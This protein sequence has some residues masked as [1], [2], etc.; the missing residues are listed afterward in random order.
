MWGQSG[1]VFVSVTPMQ[2]W[3]RQQLKMG[4]AKSQ[5]ALVEK[6][7]LS[8]D[9]GAVEPLIYAL[10]GK[11]SK[12]RCT[13]AKALWKFQDRRAV[14]PLIPLLGDPVSLVRATA[15]ESLGRLGDPKAVDDLVALMRDA[16]PVVR[17]IAARNL[18]RLGWRPASD[19]LRV[20]QILALGNL[21]QLVEMGTEG[22]A[23]LLETLRNGSPNKQ[24]AAVK[25]LGQFRG[26]PRV[27]PAML[28]ALRK[29][30]P[31]VR[32]AALGVLERLADPTTYPEV[33]R[34]L[35]DPHSSVRSCAV[36]AAFRCGGQRA[37]PALV[38]CLK[39]SFWEVRL[40][41]AGALGSLGDASAVDGLCELIPDP[42]RD[43]R[44]KAIKSLGKIGHRR[45]LVPLVPAL[46]DAERVVRDA[47]TV[48]LET[49]DFRWPQDKTALEALPQIQR[50]LQH[51]DYWVRYCA[52]KLLELLRVDVKD[53]PATTSVAA[54]AA[55][56]TP[57]HPAYSILADLLFDRDRDFR[58]A[59]AEALGQLRDKRAVSILTESTRDADDHV[60]QAAEAALAALN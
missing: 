46:F 3:T 8:D 51:P 6:L 40:M 10:K 31:T 17:A 14:S 35:E 42:D 32:V 4:S 52:G 38:K 25:A 36:E 45:A 47:A 50:A 44:E 59:A 55:D 28:E 23:P 11:E 34:L 19:S 20:L 49:I 18:N 30:T 41:A 1:D 27:R 56:E 21:N 60:Q 5:L 33:E 2:W 7:A 53:L 26:E 16:D 22:I 9:A 37:V 43:V 13:A 12:V 29:N 24:L 48:A 58:L 54:P 15:A 57:G 39:D